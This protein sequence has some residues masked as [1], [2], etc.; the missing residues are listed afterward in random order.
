[1]GRLPRFAPAGLPQHVT[2]R[3]NYG[4]DVFFADA[5]RHL[6]LSLL[7]RHSAER[8]IRVIAYTLMTNHVHLILEPQSDDG[9]SI[10]MQ[11]LQ[12]EYARWMHARRDS[13]GHLWRHHYDACVMDETH[14]GIALAYVE[15]NPV[16]AGITKTAVDY[17]WSSA[18]AHTGAAPPHALLHKKSFTDR[19]TTTDW[20]A[21]L[22][23]KERDQEELREELA[24]IRRATRL[25]QP[26]A[27][28]DFVERL[29][30]KHRRKLNRRPPGRPA[31]VATIQAA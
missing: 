24:A 12:S 10:M 25:N 11:C 27:A 14:L 13:L 1:M 19:F 21:I 17:E 31:K 16:R 30:S 3:G 8:N 15:M 28:A 26:L 7:D 4:Q 20:A 5:D 2:Q 29:E 6:Y 9:L 22:H 18:R 23:K